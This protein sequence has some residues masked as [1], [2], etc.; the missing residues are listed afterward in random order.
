MLL[1][2]LVNN[3]RIFIDLIIMGMADVVIT[4]TP[5]TIA[6]PAI[7]PPDSW[8][9][10]HIG[11]SA[12]TWRISGAFPGRLD[13][14]LYGIASNS[15]RAA[16]QVEWNKLILNL[17]LPWTISTDTLVP[18]SRYL[19]RGASVLGEGY[20]TG[21]PTLTNQR[22]TLITDRNFT[23]TNELTKRMEPTLITWTFDWVWNG[24][25]EGR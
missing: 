1:D 3:R 11:E 4:Y 7:S 20:I 10:R 23:R 19:A 15:R 24:K 21:K 12:H 25:L 16:A 17:T 8:D 22:M 14:T 5:Q 6:T 18:P 9:V 13:T 2:S